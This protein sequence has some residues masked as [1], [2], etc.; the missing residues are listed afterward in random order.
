MAQYILA[1]AVVL[2]RRR[3]GRWDDIAG[4]LNVTAEQTREQHAAAIE[5]WKRA[6]ATAARSRRVCSRRATMLG[7]IAA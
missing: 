5:K 6:R 7:A 3:G 4:T 1:C 2:A